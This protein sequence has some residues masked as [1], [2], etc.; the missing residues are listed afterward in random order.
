MKRE[1]LDHQDKFF[2]MILSEAVPGVPERI[3]AAYIERLEKDQES[4]RYTAFAATLRRGTLCLHRLLSEGY[5]RLDG[6]KRQITT[7]VI[8]LRQVRGVDIESE[9][10]GFGAETFRGTLHLHHPVQGWDAP[11]KL[12]LKGPGRVDE[13]RHGKTAKDFVFAVTEALSS[14]DPTG[15]RG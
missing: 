13:Q 15:E 8:P 14:I 4:G 6:E 1:S 5:N 9:V 7:T 2:A 11:I 12:P 3:E 10:S